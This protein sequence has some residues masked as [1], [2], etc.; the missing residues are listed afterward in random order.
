MTFTETQQEIVGN[1][2]WLSREGRG[3]VLGDDAAAEADEL[4]EAG[5]LTTREE[6][7]GDTSYWWSPAGELALEL[8]GLR[9]DTPAD[10][11]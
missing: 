10:L 7:N 3:M 11:N 5:W 8:G 4:V 6:P 1:A 9:R 2:Y